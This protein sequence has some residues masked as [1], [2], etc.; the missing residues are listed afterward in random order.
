MIT[1]DALLLPSAVSAKTSG[2]ILDKLSAGFAANDHAIMAS[3]TP[4]KQSAKL[5]ATRA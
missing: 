2:A 1:I 5:T 3:R 4:P